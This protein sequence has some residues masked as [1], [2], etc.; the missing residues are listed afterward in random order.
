MKKVE[1]LE[2]ERKKY[3]ERELMLLRNL[4]SISLMSIENFYRYT[5]VVVTLKRHYYFHPNVS[6][7][8]STSLPCQEIP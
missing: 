4:E 8:N 1:K 6:I 2:K 3:K 7:K 5:I